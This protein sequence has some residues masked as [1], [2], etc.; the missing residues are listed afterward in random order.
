MFSVKA[1]PEFCRHNQKSGQDIQA[2]KICAQKKGNGKPRNDGAAQILFRHVVMPQEQ[3]LKYADRSFR[4]QK[5]FP[6]RPEIP[7]QGQNQN[8]K[9]HRQHL[10]MAGIG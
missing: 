4:Q 2:Q 7:V 5:D 6:V 9:E 1:H 10:E 8:Q 3:K